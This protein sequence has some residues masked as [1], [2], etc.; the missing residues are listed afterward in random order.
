MNLLKETRVVDGLT[1][2]IVSETREI[3]RVTKKSD[4]RQWVRLYLGAWATIK[5]M[6][7]IGNQCLDV[8]YLMLRLL[9]VAYAENEEL[10]V[11]VPS[12]YHKDEWAKELKTTRAVINKHIQK[13]EKEG[14][15][16]RVRR[17]GKAVRGAYVINPQLIGYGTETN[18]DKLRR[19]Y[20]T[21]QIDENGATIHPV[22]ECDDKEQRH[23][24]TQG[25]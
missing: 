7:G 17:D 2:E 8:L 23:E 16:S 14:V 4:T 3:S 12:V 19:I 10:P 1:G 24:E 25:R 22:L 9:P 18:V 6:R 11:V 13:L 21:F 15:I 20:G 5:G